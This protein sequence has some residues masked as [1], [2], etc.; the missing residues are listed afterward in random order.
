MSPVL[1]TSAHPDHLLVMT[2]EEQQH[3][4][5]KSRAT[6]FDALGGKNGLTFHNCDG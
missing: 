2:E 4:G 1:V 5:L 3:R 6:A